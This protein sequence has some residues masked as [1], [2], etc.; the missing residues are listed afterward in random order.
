MLYGIGTI[1][2]RFDNTKIKE[3]VPDFNA[4]TK[5]ED[6]IKETIKY[7]N[8][9]TEMKKVNYLWDARIDGLIDKY[10]KSIKKKDYDRT[11]LTLKSYK[12][13]LGMK[14]KIKYL[15]ARNIDLYNLLKKAK[16]IIKR[17]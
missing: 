5:F 15:S 1:D 9:H 3:V 16:Y 10:Y 2:R 4:Q 8:E 6:G 7:Y 14:Q 13:K 11:K 12:N 17:R